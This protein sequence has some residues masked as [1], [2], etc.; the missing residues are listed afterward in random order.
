MKVYAAL[1]L[2]SGTL[3]LALPQNIGSGVC[4]PGILYTQPQCC[5]TD[6]FNI[7]NLDCQPRGSRP[8]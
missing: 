5:Q 6:V 2:C 1:V 4:P 3:T 7:A 8:Y